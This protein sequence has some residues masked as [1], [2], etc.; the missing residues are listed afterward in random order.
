M[1]PSDFLLTTPEVENIVA[2]G[3]LM[4]GGLLSHGAMKA[5]VPPWRF[6]GFLYSGMPFS[7]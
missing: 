3:R 7:T 6:R 1:Q 5:P 2:I 4:A